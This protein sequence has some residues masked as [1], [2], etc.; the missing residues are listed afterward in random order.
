[1]RLIRH[2]SLFPEVE[3]A[4]IEA[5]LEQ[6]VSAIKHSIVDHF[7]RLNEPL[8]ADAAN[9]I[10]QS[11]TP[12]KI[13]WPRFNGDLLKAMKLTVY[14]RYK[15]WLENVVFRG[16]KRPYDSDSEPELDESSADEPSSD[17]SSSVGYQPKGS[18][19]ARAPLP[20]LTNPAPP[21]ASSRLDR[22]SVHAQ[23]RGSKTRPVANRRA[24][25]SGK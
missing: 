5:L 19:R 18:A 4:A 14:Q 2:Q 15:Y 23:P 6:G 9:A 24:T 8:E 13:R 11:H 3:T 25:G 21:R 1:M 7:A 20:G 16:E 17:D 10:I 12:L 22:P